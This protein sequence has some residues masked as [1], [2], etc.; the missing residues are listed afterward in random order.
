[1]AAHNES[2][3][4]SMRIGEWTVLFDSLLRQ[5]G[6]AIDLADSNADVDVLRVSAWGAALIEL[7]DAIRQ[8]MPRRRGKP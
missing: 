1:M 2:V 6:A 8:R 4:L 3:I 7:V 5:S